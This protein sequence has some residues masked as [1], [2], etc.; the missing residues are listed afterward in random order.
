M[1][2]EEESLWNASGAEAATCGKEIPNATAI[3]VD[4]G[5][6]GTVFFF[7]SFNANELGNGLGVAL[8]FALNDNFG[9]TAFFFIK[10]DP[11]TFYFDVVCKESFLSGFQFVGEPSVELALGNGDTVDAVL[12]SVLDEAGNAGWVIRAIIFQAA[13]YV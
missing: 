8:N 11:D 12:G 6:E 2:K 3:F 10:A 1:G 13:L 4:V 9:A 5:G 7:L